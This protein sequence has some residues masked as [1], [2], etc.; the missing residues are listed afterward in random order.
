MPYHTNFDAPPPT[1]LRVVDRPSGQRSG[2]RTRHRERSL[3]Q[4]SA[5][6]SEADAAPEV[7]MLA[8]FRDGDP[9]RSRA[10]VRRFQGRVYGLAV[11]MTGDPVWAEDIAQ[12]ALLRAWRGAS[13][14]DPSRGSVTTWL[15][16]ITRNAALDALRRHRPESVSP[17]AEAFLQIVATDPP[18]TEVVILEDEMGAVRDALGR[19]PLGQRRA[20]VLAALFRLTA[21][22]IAEAEGIPLGTA[23]TRIRSGMLKLRAELHVTDPGRPAV[24]GG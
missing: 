12:D 3:S 16:T 22:E 10:F 21:T 18:P 8:G 2:G 17:H 7:A 23:K 24:A 6:L 19:V 20:V 9:E 15:L 14:F 1:E 4:D 5:A 13:S 11:K